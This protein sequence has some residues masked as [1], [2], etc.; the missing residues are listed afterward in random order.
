M[1]LEKL[2]QRN[3]NWFG[4]SLV[5]LLASVVLAQFGLRTAPANAVYLGIVFLVLT[6]LPS[7]LL[8]EL[9]P[10]WRKKNS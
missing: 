8:T 5:S 4:L 2:W 7:N 6:L 9:A 3:R 1:F 10:K